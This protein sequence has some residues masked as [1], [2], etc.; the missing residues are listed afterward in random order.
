MYNSGIVF[1]AHTKIRSNR[2]TVKTDSAG[3]T[4]VQNYNIEREGETNEIFC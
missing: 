4:F 3:A 1:H 2:A